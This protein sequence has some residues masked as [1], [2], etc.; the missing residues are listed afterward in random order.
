MQ[1]GKPF[2]PFV[3]VARLSALPHPFSEIG[4][5]GMPSRLSGAQHNPF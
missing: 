3:A 5:Y 2:H 1:S 4:S